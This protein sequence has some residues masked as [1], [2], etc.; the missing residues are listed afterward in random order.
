VPGSPLILCNVWDA[1][2]AKAVTA[3]GA[4]AL[5]SSSWAV[6]AAN[7]YADGERV[8]LDLVFHNAARI[9]K[10]TP[11]PVSIDIEAGYGAS[12]REVGDSVRSLLDAGAVGCN[13]EDSFPEDGRLRSME[14]QVERLR[15]GRGAASAAAIPLF[16]NARTDVFFST[17]VEHHSRA[18]VAAALDRARA[19]A[20]AGANGLFVPG[21]KNRELIRELCEGSPVPVNI[22]LDD[23]AASVAGLAPL[24]VARVSYGPVPY[25]L[26]MQAL[27]DRARTM[28]SGV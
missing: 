22:M 19:Y 24:G 6:A 4:R 14:E 11:L 13:I 26:A 23:I 18:T 1:G 9:A 12:A 3:A 20:A 21:V 27:T 8:P 16:L 2:A 7:G 25:L 17:P 15:A 5:G 10:A 28:L